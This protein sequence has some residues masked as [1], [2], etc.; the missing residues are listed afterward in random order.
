MVANQEK[1][2]ENFIVTWFPVIS[3]LETNQVSPKN[4]YCNLL[5][6]NF[7][8]LLL[9]LKCFKWILLNFFESLHVQNKNKVFFLKKIVLMVQYECD[10]PLDSL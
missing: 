10:C 5:Y 2:I 7:I 4:K 6:F 3:Y 1:V 9:N 8:L